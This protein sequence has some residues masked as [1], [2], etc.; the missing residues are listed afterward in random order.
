VL[1]EQK[2][3]QTMGVVEICLGPILQQYETSVGPW[4]HT[5]QW[6]GRRKRTATQA[7]HESTSRWLRSC[8]NLDIR[9]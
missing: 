4:R 9:T 5:R 2:S 1:L 3:D 6:L 7:W 8:W